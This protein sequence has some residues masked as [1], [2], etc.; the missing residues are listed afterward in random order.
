MSDSD[1]AAGKKKGGK[2]LIIGL[3]LALLLGGG[4][5]YGVYSG[6]VP[7]PFGEAETAQAGHGEAA[8]GHGET[9]HAA[10]AG[11]GGAAGDGHGAP[12]PEPEEP[13]PPAAFLQLEPVTV[14]IGG[15]DS[16]RQ[17]QMTASL[18]VEPAMEAEAI[19]LQ[20]RARDALNTY[21]RAVNPAD[22]ENPA[23]MLRM[24]AQML[25]RLQVVMG[26]GVVRDLLISDFILR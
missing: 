23:A 9:A 24:R 17:L 19:L 8:A 6:L 26:E 4:G 1:D 21:L 2:G 25:R 12:L 18:E 14:T 15:A 20:P 11:H 16:F 13:L 22:V 10:A 7:L 5:F 3:A